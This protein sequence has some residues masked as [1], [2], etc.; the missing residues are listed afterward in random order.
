MTGCGD[1]TLGEIDT[2][3]SVPYWHVKDHV[4]ASFLCRSH[5]HLL[6]APNKLF[7]PGT[8]IKYSIQFN[9]GSL[10][11]F[12]QTT[13]VYQPYSRLQ[14]AHAMN[15]YLAW[16]GTILYW[17]SWPIGIVLFY[18]FAAVL[19]LLKL[20]YYPIAFILSPV[21]YLL[22]FI[23]ACLALPFRALV[24]LEVS[25]PSFIYSM[26]RVTNCLIQPLYNYIGVAALIGLLGGLALFYIYSIFH[27]LLRLDST[28]DPARE[29]TFKQY[30][31]EKAQQKARSQ[32]PTML[33]PGNAAINLTN[34]YS[35]AAG[36]G[37]PRN[38]LDQTIMEELDSD[39]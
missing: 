26:V 29:R 33:P 8:R 11:Q 23:A 22:R 31:Q 35:S 36:Q 21:V 14:P 6:I 37:G 38:L 3:A 30:R 39:Y 1:E 19:A 12:D 9:P 28:P 32:P 27:R 25:G 24:K 10:A 4:P 17:I 20:T 5:T 2:S 16:T 15:I 18:L 13:G 7:W 34:G